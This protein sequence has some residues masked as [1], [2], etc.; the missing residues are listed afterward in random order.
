MPVLVIVLFLLLPREFSN[1][2]P[3][4][5]SSPITYTTTFQGQSIEWKF[6]RHVW[7]EVLFL[8]PDEEETRGKE[9]K[10]LMTISG[11]RLT[12]EEFR[13]SLNAWQTKRQN[14]Q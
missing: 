12:D 8:W 13:E 11:K 7:N 5:S 4:Y 1:A 3:D 6:D 9:E 2:Q 10:T 14:F